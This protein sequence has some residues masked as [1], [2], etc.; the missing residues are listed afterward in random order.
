MEVIYW[1]IR[2]ALILA[3]FVLLGKAIVRAH[4]SGDF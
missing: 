2:G 4:E 3:L 1:I